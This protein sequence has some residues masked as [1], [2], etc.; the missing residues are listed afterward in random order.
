MWRPGGKGATGSMFGYMFVKN[1]G[2]RACFLRGRPI[3]KAWR[4]NGDPAPVHQ[5][6]LPA[7]S[8]NPDTPV[9]LAPG[10]SAHADITWRDWRE[11]RA[12]VGTIRCVLPDGTGT[13][14]V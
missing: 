9:V 8:G 11:T 6:S 4:M 7:A 2:K 10:A 1:T 3:I 14:A 13:L 5:L 12:S